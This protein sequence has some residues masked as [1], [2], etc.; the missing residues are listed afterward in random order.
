MMEDNEMN[1]SIMAKI[2]EIS[3]HEKQLLKALLSDIEF[4]NARGYIEST[5]CTALIMLEQAL[6]YV[7]GYRKY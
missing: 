5:G 3:E 2:P 7:A 4:D 1:E 6:E